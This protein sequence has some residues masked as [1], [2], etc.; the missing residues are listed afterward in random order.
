MKK[1]ELDG[2]TKQLYVFTLFMGENHQNLSKKVMDLGIG[3]IGDETIYELTNPEGRPWMKITKGEKVSHPLVLLTKK[4]TIQ[5]SEDEWKKFLN[6]EAIRCGLKG[7]KYYSLNLD[8]LL[9]MVNFNE[10]LL[11]ALKVSYVHQGKQ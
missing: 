6:G 8:E 5:M 4:S 7:R 2:A 3:L 1:F 9:K 11:G 10:D